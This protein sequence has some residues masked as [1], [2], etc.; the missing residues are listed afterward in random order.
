[1]KRGEIDIAYSI[2]GELAEELR[3]TP[4]LALKSVVTQATN[5]IYFPEQWDPK[6]PWHDQR[7]RQAACLALDRNAMNDA[8]FLGGCKVSNSAVVPST[9]EFYW[10][11][12]AA[13][14]DPAKAKKL[15]A[16]AG[17]PAGFDAGPFWCDSSYSNIGEVAVNALQEIGIRTKLTAGRTRRLHLG[18]RGQEATTRA[19]CATP[20]GRSAN[21]A[22]RL[23]VVCRER[24]PERLWQL[25]RYRR[26]VPGAGQRARSEEANGGSDKMQQLVH[27]KAIYAPL[28]ELCLPERRRPPGR[29]SPLSA[30]LPGS[31][32]PAARSRTSRSTAPNAVGVNAT[33]GRPEGGGMTPGSHRRHRSRAAIHRHDAPRHAGARALWVCSPARC[34]PP[35][36]A[37]KGQLT[38]AGAQCH[39]RRPGSTRP[40]PR[41]HHAL[42]GALRAA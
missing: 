6:S 25:S 1:L 31:R 39:W 42:H 22:T 17:H 34:A 20:A 27:E 18:L 35:L 36:A 19:S 10:Q 33:G 9:F 14:Y 8:L 11:P 2:R 40:R 21:A 32:T 38:W 4:G 15:L 7:V 29:T 3:Q 24:W 23:C 12:P 16:E 5:S 30:G 26:A 41:D 37:R 13:A 28:W